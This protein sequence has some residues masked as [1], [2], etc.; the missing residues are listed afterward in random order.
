MF[1][2]QKSYTI[3]GY[4]W[5]I[6]YRIAKDFPSEIY[7]PVN[8]WIISDILDIHTEPVWR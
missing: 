3:D 5:I 6:S 7:K 8:L 2:L 4:N 1:S